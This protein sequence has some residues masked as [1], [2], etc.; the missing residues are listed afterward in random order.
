ME[1]INLDKKSNE[2]PFQLLDERKLDSISKTTKE[3]EKYLESLLKKRNDG[4]V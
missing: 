4:T 2:V 3:A 1:L